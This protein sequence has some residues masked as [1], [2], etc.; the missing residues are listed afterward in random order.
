MVHI[1]V[2][3]AQQRCVYARMR[4]VRWITAIS[5]DYRHMRQCIKFRILMILVC[6]LSLSSIFIRQPT[7]LS[8]FPFVFEFKQQQKCVAIARSLAWGFCFQKYSL[9]LYS[10]YKPPLAPPAPHG[11]KWSNKNED[12]IRK[13]KIIKMLET[14]ISETKPKKEQA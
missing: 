7:I 5:C 6:P 12:R 10:M 9:C 4:S 14:E 11:S 8:L 3:I 13:K 2:G 1:Q